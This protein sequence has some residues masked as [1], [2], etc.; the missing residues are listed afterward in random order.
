[1]YVRDGNGRYYN[2]DDPMSRACASFAH[3]SHLGGEARRRREQ[4]EAR[5]RRSWWRRRFLSKPKA[6]AAE[7]VGYELTLD[8]LR[9]V[10]P[11]SQ[12]ADG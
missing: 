2:P 7:I 1:M 12:A 6:E 3:F 10:A 11:E 8:M 5:W 9:A 4:R